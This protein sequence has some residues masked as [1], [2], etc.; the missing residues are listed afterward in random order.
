MVQLSSE[1]SVALIA[2]EQS[3][4][5]HVTTDALQKVEFGGKTVMVSPKAQRRI[6]VVQPH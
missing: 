1:V 5:C 3:R 2:A 4:Q 6:N